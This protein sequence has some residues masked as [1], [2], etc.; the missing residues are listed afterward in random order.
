MSRIELILPHLCE[1]EECKE[2][3]TCK[4]YNSYRGKYCGSFCKGHGQAKLKTLTEEE[5]K[6][7]RISVAKVIRNHIDEFGSDTLDGIVNF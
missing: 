4:V 6:R 1:E 2:L 5:I 3:V 7:S